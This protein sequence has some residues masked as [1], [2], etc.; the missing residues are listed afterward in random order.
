MKLERLNKELKELL[1]APAYATLFSEKP[2]ACV[3]LRR[4]RDILELVNMDLGGSY[5]SLMKRKN[6]QEGASEWSSR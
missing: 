4:I 2:E 1:E 6:E 5:E 3:R